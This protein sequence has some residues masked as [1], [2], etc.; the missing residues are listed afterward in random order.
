MGVCE[1]HSLRKAKRFQ[2]GHTWAQTVWLKGPVGLPDAHRL[3]G[4]LP[5]ISVSCNP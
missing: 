4:G 5:Q 2:V 3:L 1:D